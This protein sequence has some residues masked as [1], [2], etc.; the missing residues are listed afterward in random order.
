MK[1]VQRK[2]RL[3]RAGCNRAVKDGLGVADDYRSK[4]VAIYSQHEAL[5]KRWRTR[6]SSVSSGLPTRFVDTP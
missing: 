6:A 4:F 5:F 2:Q 1:L 3:R